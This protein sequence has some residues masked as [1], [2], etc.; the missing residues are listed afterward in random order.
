[1]EGDGHVLVLHSIPARQLA[2]KLS[3]WVAHMENKSEPDYTLGFTV[4]KDIRF[5]RHGNIIVPAHVQ[6][7]I[8]NEQEAVQGAH[9]RGLAPRVEEEE[10]RRDDDEEQG[11]K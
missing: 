2:A 8:F 7:L 1:M 9:A 3:T 6:P 4:S 11:S 5:D 10:A